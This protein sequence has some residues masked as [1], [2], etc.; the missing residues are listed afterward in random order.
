[1]H[2]TCTGG[3]SVSFTATAS[4][5]EIYWYDAPV[6]GNLSR[7]WRY[8]YHTICLTSSKTYYVSASPEGCATTQRIAV[9]A[10]VDTTPVV[11]PAPS[12][13]NRCDEDRVGFLDFDLIADQTPQILTGLDPILNPV[14]T[15]FEVLYFDN[16]PD[17]EANTTAAI[18][19][20]PYRVNTS[21]N[22]T[23]YARVHNSNNHHVL[24]YC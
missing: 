8:I 1:M 16:L 13:I 23:I 21:D 14:L 2:R 24:Y 15:D 12:D 17:A 6:G 22:P 5:G 20:N 3:T 18:I 7:N 4:E 19:A 11:I 10:I 9:E